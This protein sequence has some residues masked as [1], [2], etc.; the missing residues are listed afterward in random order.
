M[1]WYKKQKQRT[2]NVIDVKYKC[3]IT[4]EEQIVRCKDL[5]PTRWWVEFE[6]DLKDEYPTFTEMIIVSK[7]QDVL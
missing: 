6:D 2:Y 4:G 5:E 1:N 3:R 7:N